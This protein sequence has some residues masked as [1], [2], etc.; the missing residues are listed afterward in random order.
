MRFQERLDGE[1][2][3]P[4]GSLFHSFGAATEKA[5]SPQDGTQV[6]G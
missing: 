1:V 5:R 4:I 6:L 2:I 3:S